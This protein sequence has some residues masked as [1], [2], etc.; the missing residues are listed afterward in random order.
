[1]LCVPTYKHYL[2]LLKSA[3]FTAF[4]CVLS[5]YVNVV[6]VNMSKWLNADKSAQSPPLEPGIIR[7]LTTLSR[8]TDNH[9]INPFYQCL[10][11]LDLF[12]DKGIHL[13]R[14]MSLL[15]CFIGHC[16][17]QPLPACDSFL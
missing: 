4:G 16:S 6:P 8:Q 3:E 15:I 2:L 1:M 14:K 10:R 13:R 5:K 17:F 12:K 11:R 9:L 7:I